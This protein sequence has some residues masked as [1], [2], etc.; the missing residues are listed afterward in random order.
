MKQSTMTV[1]GRIGTEPTA[2]AFVITVKP[3]AGVD[4]IK[5]L[6]GVLYYGR[7][8]AHRAVGAAPNVGWMLRHI[9]NS[10][11]LSRS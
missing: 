1:E 6:R 4:P 7:T 8:K 10:P 5:A 9:V 11:D 3:R 2:R